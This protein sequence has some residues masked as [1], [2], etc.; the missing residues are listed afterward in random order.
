LVGVGLVLEDRAVGVLL[1]S[2]RSQRA[3]TVGWDVWGGFASTMTHTSRRHGG[4]GVV[5]VGSMLEDRA[6]RFLLH[7]WRR[8]DDDYV[9]DVGRGGSGK[10]E[11]VWREGMWV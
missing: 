9:L 10:E 6:V 4:G 11:V 7:A 3:D 2:S 1:W 8:Y 5:G